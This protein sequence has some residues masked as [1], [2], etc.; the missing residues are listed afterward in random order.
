MG[1]KADGL[2]WPDY[3]TNPLGINF[4]ASFDPELVAA[5]SGRTR[6]LSMKRNLGPVLG[7]RLDWK[8][9]M[10]LEDVIYGISN[11]DVD[12]LASGLNDHAISVLTTPLYAML[13]VSAAATR[14]GGLY[15][16]RFPQPESRLR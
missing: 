5:S 12:A 1:V 9:L 2:D 14:A 10:L 3:P 8:R 13:I 15:R 16:Q 11:K 6:N 7:R 4:A